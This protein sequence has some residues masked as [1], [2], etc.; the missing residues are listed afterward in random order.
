MKLVNKMCKYERDLAIIVE[1]T[2]QTRLC[3]QTDGQTV[4][5][6]ETGITPFPGLDLKLCR[7]VPDR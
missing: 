7:T 6:S 2:E 4:E 3:P 5:Q 1:D